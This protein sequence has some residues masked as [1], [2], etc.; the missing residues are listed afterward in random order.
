MPVG[1]HRSRRCGSNNAF[2]CREAQNPPGQII[3]ANPTATLPAA[4]LND[5]QQLA[6]G[7]TVDPDL[8]AGGAAVYAIQP[9]ADGR[10]TAQA[11]AGSSSLELRLS[12]F[13]AAG[14]LLVQ[15]DGQ[16]SGALNPLIDQ[17]ITAGANYRLEVQS[18]S[19]SGAYSLSTSLLAASVP[20]QAVAISSNPNG[21]GYVP[22][23]AGDFANNGVLD[24]V[25]VDGVHIGTGDGTFEAPAPG[26]A[27]IDPSYQ[28]SASAIA[29][30]DFNGDGNLDAAVALAGNDSISI[31]LGNGNGT[32]Q[33]ATIVPLPPGSAP[34]AIV[35]GDFTG[36]GYT[37]L[38]VADGGTNDVIILKNDGKGNFT[39]V[40]T[41]PVGSY[42]DALVAGDF[43]NGRLD[44]A[45]ANF[46]SSNV[47]IISNQGGGVFQPLAPIALP[48]G[49][50]P[51][52][53]VAGNFGTGQV[54]LA[55]TDYSR[56]Q[57]EH[58]AGPGP[59]DV[60][61]RVV[62]QRRGSPRCDRHRRLRQRAERPR[63]RRRERCV[64]VAGQW[65]RHIPA[66]DPHAHG[67][68][69]RVAGRPGCGRFQWRRPH[70]FGRGRPH[71]H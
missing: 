6:I 10:L 5:A 26:D 21:W 2:C 1:R 70:R 29:V 27:L 15:S 22:L 4:L 68:S 13:D 67:D 69:S 54:D 32:F 71:L 12:L 11:Q 17:Y 52:A 49:S 16:A 59:R 62:N 39:I 41:I 42:P 50:T 34:Q 61:A 24:L 3:A 40:D 38:A 20:N 31:S 55:V 44:L 51:S 60:P 18:L 45:V 64:G 25:A 53:I 9:S 65:R 46:Y 43:G 57:V 48:L 28:S 58:P 19:G 63:R 47:T 37:D 14:D 8:T 66:R 36:H 56:S 23:A 33:P 30:G 7:A 35:A